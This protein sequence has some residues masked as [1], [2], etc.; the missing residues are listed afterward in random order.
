MNRAARAKQFM[1]FDALKGLQ[2]ALIEREERR[3]MV[4]KKELSEEEEYELNVA[5]NRLKKGDS[6][7]IVFYRRGFYFKH[8]GI[9]KKV[10]LQTRTIKTD[11]EQISFEDLLSIHIN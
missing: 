2:E 9:V 11:G 3:L 6:V 7:V 5:L 10:N 8:D 1:P 4:K